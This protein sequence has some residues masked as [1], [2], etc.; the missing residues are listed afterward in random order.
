MRRNTCQEPL[1]HLD[2]P[3]PRPA[4]PTAQRAR[5]VLMA[6]V[7]RNKR[8]RA[9]TASASSALSAQTGSDR[10]SQSLALVSRGRAIRGYYN[11]ARDMPAVSVRGGGRSDPPESGARFDHAAGT[12]TSN[13]KRLVTWAS[14]AREPRPTHRAEFGVTELALASPAQRRGRGLQFPRT[15]SVGHQSNFKARRG[16]GRPAHF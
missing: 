8:A 9:A 3:W 16:P 10:S 11:G 1:G 2:R 7:G 15:A 14:R 5:V 6:W 13:G 4:P 12:V